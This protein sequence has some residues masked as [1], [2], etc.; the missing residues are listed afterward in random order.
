M[1][2]APRSYVA[3]DFDVDAL[4]KAKADAGVTISVCI[5]ARDEELTVGGVVATIRRELLDRHALVDEILVVDDRS[6]DE[7]A[8][9]ARSAGARVVEADEVLPQCG[10]TTGKGEALWKS[11]AASSGDLVVWCDAD[12][13]G[14]D[15]RF[16]IGLVAPLLL[17]DDVDFVKGWYE[18]NSGRV[19]ELTARPVIALLHPQLAAFAQ[20]L[21]GEY[22]GRRALLE[23][24][25]FATGYG[26]DL[27]LLIDVADAVGL[28]RMAQV[29]LGVR[30]HR[31]RPLEELSPQAV[32]VLRVAL[33]RA[34]VELSAFPTLLHR[35]GMDDVTI[36]HD[37]RP[38]LVDVAAYRR[39]A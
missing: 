28:D 5:P 24:L 18:R 16:V 14:F 38:P 35:A 3:A 25:P 1:S 10:A 7:T 30:V 34:G 8:A 32:A 13:R 33:D 36:G 23:R 12:V 20:P 9:V 37:E 26:V 17:D 22:A 6:S 4:C 31:N 27:A 39:S 15:A 29:D 11:L 21:S 2:G 19:T